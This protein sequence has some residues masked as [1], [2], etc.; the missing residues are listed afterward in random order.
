MKNLLIASIVLA[1]ASSAFTQGTVI[2]NLRMSGT[3]HVYA[4]HT[5][6]LGQVGQGSNDGVPSGT[7]DWS[8]WTAIGANGLTG[9]Y[10]AQST[11][12]S[13]LGG[14]ARAA[15]SSL[16]PGALGTTLGGGTATTFRTGVAAGANANATATF[17]NIAPDAG[18]ANFEVVAWDNFSGQYSTWS[19]ATA[20][21]QVGLIALGRSGLFSLHQIGGSVNTAP[22]LFPTSTSTDTVAMQS[23]GLCF[24]CIPE[25]SVATLAALGTGTLSLLCRQRRRSKR[26]AL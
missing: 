18:V 21:W 22:P 5:P 24:D 19:L 26:P 7:T 15:E 9:Q 17:S 13:I 6:D 20:A 10:G 3:S 2:F 23:F 14:P 4:P 12:I 16:I 25:P 11:F 1:N 8:G